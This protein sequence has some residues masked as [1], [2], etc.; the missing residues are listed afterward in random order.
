MILTL[1]R[2]VRFTKAKKYT[3]NIFMPFTFQM[4]PV[5]VN[6]SSKTTITTSAGTFEC[7]RV[8]LSSL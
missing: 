8:S 3:F 2:S 7:E 6:S 5:T 1:L 4:T